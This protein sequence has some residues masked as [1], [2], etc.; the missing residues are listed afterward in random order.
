LG[1][2]VEYLKTLPQDAAVY[3]ADGESYRFV[4]DYTDW[5]EDDNASF[6]I[7]EVAHRKGQTVEEQ[8]AELDR[9]LEKGHIKDPKGLLAQTITHDEPKTIVTLIGCR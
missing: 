9:T 1:G 5:D 7:Q 6:P 4:E 8:H 3:V 2:L